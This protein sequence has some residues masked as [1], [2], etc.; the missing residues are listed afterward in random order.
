MFAALS[1]SLAPFPQAMFFKLFLIRTFKAK[2][3]QNS[4]TW[5]KIVGVHLL[6]RVKI[7]KT[8]LVLYVFASLQL[9]VI[10][11]LWSVFG[12]APTLY[13]LHLTLQLALVNAK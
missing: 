7:N 13:Q 5:L 1:S 9:A 6:E 4:H 2:S 12:A 10:L 3:M 11:F 8:I